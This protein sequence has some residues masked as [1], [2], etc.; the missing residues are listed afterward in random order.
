MAIRR[1]FCSIK[2]AGAG[3]LLGFFGV[4]CPICNKV[5][6][7]LF[8]GELLLTYYEPARIY[9]AAAGV[10]VAVAVVARELTLLRRQSAEAMAAAG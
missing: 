5:L 2:A 1:P 3:G 9:L 6:L 8:G 4:A 7:L 10:L